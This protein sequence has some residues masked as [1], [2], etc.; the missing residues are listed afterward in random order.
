MLGER[1]LVLFY[2]QRARFARQ[3]KRAGDEYDVFPW[4]LRE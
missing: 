1:T 3:V 2:E 4:R